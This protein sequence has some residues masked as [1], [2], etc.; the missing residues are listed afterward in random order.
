[1]DRQTGFFSWLIKACLNVVY[2]TAVKVDVSA[3]YV[4]DSTQLPTMVSRARR[5]Y[6]TKETC[7]VSLPV[8][9]Q[10]VNAITMGSIDINYDSISG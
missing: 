1:M 5:V 9:H 6:I 8:P 7:Y 2:N 10:A 4:F 3:F